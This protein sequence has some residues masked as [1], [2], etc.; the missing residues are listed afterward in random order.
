MQAANRLAE[1]AVNVRSEA[2]EAYHRY[3]ANYDIARHY[4]NS[5]LPLRKIIQDESL[6][7]YS[8]MLIDVTD[9]ITDARA[10]ILSNVEAINAR[11]DFWI[12]HTDFKHALVGGGGGGG[13]GGARSRR[14]AA[15]DGGGALALGRSRRHDD[16]VPQRVHRLVRASCWPARPPSPAAP[17]APSVPEAPTMARRRCRRRSTRQRP[18]LPAGRDPQ[19][20]DAALAHERRLEGVPS[21]RRA[22]RSA[23]SRPA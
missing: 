17:P 5:V 4:Q 14:L 8:G 15:A 20:L 13:G 16:A 11:R 22:G 12:A 6:L 3:R 19:R 2:R 21:R 1:R 18:G 9:L 7:H 23:S 10:R